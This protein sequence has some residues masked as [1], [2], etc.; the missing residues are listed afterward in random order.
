V[1]IVAQRV[2]SASVTVGGG[3]R[4]KI[5]PGLCVFVG[6]APEDTE[7][8]AERLA[9][10]VLN[11]RI[12]GNSD[13]PCGDGKMNFSLLDTG[14]AVLAISQFTLY[15]DCR[16]GRRPSFTGAAPAE[17]GMKLYDHFVKC[18]K[19]RGVEAATGEFGAF[20]KVEINNE[21]PITIIMDS[22]DL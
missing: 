21:G 4:G 22:A 20:M 19:D 13:N 2:S 10:K 5:G 9:D 11:L 3:V 18:V 15:A 6:V 7:A 12:F 17:Q 14:G 8:D 1:R 16:K